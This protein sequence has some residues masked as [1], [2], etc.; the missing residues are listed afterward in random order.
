MKTNISEIKIEKNIPI[1]FGYNGGA[2]KSKLLRRLG[3]G[4]SIKIPKPEVMAWRSSAVYVRIKVKVLSISKTECRL[5]R[6]K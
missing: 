3:V 2:G 5:W 1:A 4:D 6:I